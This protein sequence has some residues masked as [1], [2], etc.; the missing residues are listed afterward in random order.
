[1]I[2]ALPLRRSSAAASSSRVTSS[3]SI[4]LVLSFDAVVS[5]GPGSLRPS[6]RPRS[7]HEFPLE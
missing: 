1:M 7:E 5:R 2:K 3:F 4:D 6:T